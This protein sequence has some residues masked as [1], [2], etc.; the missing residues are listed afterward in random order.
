MPP[1]I[2][3]PAELVAF[4]RHLAQTAK[5]VSK[6]KNKAARLI[7]ESRAVWKDAKY[8]RFRKTFEQTSKDLDRF[9]RLAEDYA[10]SLERKAAL[11]RKYL[12][13]R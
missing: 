4:A 11:G 1:V 5:N 12:D 8:D 7:S 13:N 3:T 10:H 2:V 6:R 9:V